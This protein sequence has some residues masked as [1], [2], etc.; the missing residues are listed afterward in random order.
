[1]NIC[2]NGSRGYKN[3][4]QMKLTLDIELKDKSDVTF[5]LGGA[6]G[7]DQLAERY[8]KENK[9]PFKVFK[10]DWDKHGRAA[11][12]MRNKVMISQ[13]NHLISFWDGK[14]RGTKHA[15]DHARMNSIPVTVVETIA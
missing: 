5:I 3:Y 13:S 1:M 7:A 12:I 10:P 14:S 9:I 8:A 4:S 2:I 15:I 11:G 6:R